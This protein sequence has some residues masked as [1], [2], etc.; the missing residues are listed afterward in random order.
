VGFGYSGISDN[1]EH[2][3]NVA[4]QEGV[5][6]V[7]NPSYEAVLEATYSVPINSHWQMQ[8]DLQWVIQPG[9]SDRYHNAV[10]LG[11][12]STVTF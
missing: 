8:P 3:N 5:A 12:R 1:V 7:P 4:R 11:V 9:G 10:V 6:S 2:A